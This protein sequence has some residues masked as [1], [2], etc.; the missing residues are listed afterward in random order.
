MYRRLLKKFIHLFQPPV[1]WDPNIEKPPDWRIIG[2]IIG[3]LLR[4]T[5][6]IKIYKSLTDKGY[7]EALKFQVEARRRGIPYYYFVKIDEKKRIKGEFKGYKKLR[8]EIGKRFP[9]NKLVKIYKTKYCKGLC[10]LLYQFAGET[11]PLPTL[12]EYFDTEDANKIITDLKNVIGDDGGALGTVYKKQ[13]NPESKT[14]QEAYFNIFPATIVLT[15]EGP[16]GAHSNTVILQQV[17]RNPS[18]YTAKWIHLDFLGNAEFE[19]GLN[20]IKIVDR[21]NKVT[22]DWVGGLQKGRLPQ[23]AY[24]LETRDDILRRKREPIFCYQETNFLEKYVGQGNPMDI[25]DQ[26]P[27]QLEPIANIRWSVIHYDLNAANIL[28]GGYLIDFATVDKG[29][30]AYDLAKLET[31]IKRHLL[32]IKFHNIEDLIYFEELL[33]KVPWNGGQPFEWNNLNA[34]TIAFLSEDQKKHFPK[35]F[36][37]IAYIRHCAHNHNITREDYL[38]SLYFYGIASLKF[39]QPYIY[40]RSAYISAAI[41]LKH[42]HRRTNRIGLTSTKSPSGLTDIQIKITQVKVQKLNPN[43]SIAVDASGNPIEMAKISYKI[44]DSIQRSV[45]DRDCIYSK[46]ESIEIPA[47]GETILTFIVVGRDGSGNVTPISYQ[48]RW[49]F[50][51]NCT[52]QDADEPYVLTISPQMLRE[53]QEYNLEVENQIP[54]VK[55]TTKI[56][57]VPGEIDTIENIL[58]RNGNSTLD[59]FITADDIDTTKHVVKIVGK[60]RFGNEIN[61]NI[62]PVKWYFEYKDNKTDTTLTDKTPLGE[63]VKPREEEVIDNSCTFKKYTAG[64][65]KIKAIP[66][67]DINPAEIT[68][69]VKPGKCTCIELNLVDEKDRAYRKEIHEDG[70]VVVKAQRHRNARIVAIPKDKHGNII[71]DISQDIR[72]EIMRTIQYPRAIGSV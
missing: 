45:V 60:D 58:V 9:E 1:E 42:I 59:E 53:P 40:H 5:K 18:L 63:D 37:V 64:L 68:I 32:S 67:G 49:I 22:L 34:Q 31:E 17:I 39:N 33:H 20:K 70:K 71:E 13:P 30:V 48:L 35:Y 46:L 66:E 7:S 41:A 19:R 72:E 38:N 3:C 61:K 8:K 25:I 4:W 29:P 36:N 10:G 6:S 69:K 62:P 12:K 23:W 24:I 26:L 52:K 43:N 2:K 21:D 28:E 27:I 15:A 65:W 57:I 56:K 44:L 50:N 14:Y 11:K 47:I 16:P 55:A 54:E 51:G